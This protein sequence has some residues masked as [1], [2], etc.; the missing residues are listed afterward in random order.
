MWEQ[1]C[2]ECAQQRSERSEWEERNEKGERIMA[3]SVRSFH[4]PHKVRATPKIMD[5]DL[6]KAL[7]FALLAMGI[8]FLWSMSGPRN[9][10]LPAPTT[11]APV[12]APALDTP[13]QAPALE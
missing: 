2:F 7:I 11:P 10:D 1:T 3:I 8:F 9:E 5:S 12:T 6:R 13:P 4:P